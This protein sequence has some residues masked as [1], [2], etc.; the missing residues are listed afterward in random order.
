MVK[1]FLEKVEAVGG[2]DN[3]EDFVGA[4][5]EIL[6]LSW[7]A[8]AI[9]SMFWLADSTAHGFGCRFDCLPWERPKLTPGVI[10]MVKR[11]IRFIARSLGPDA[12][13]TF[14]ETRSDI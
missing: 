14:Q 8:N 10:E 3:A 13:Q 5:R 1:R 12:D 11:K 6:G 9:K 7:R 4:V 2:A